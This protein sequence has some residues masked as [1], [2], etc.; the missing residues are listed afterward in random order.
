MFRAERFDPDQWADLFARSGAKYIALTSKHH[1]GFALWRT[2]EANRAWGRP[3]N[4]VDR[5]ETGPPAGPLR[6]PQGPSHVG[7]YYSLY[8]WYSPLWLSDRKRCVA[9]HLFPQLKRRLNHAKPRIIFSDG[10]WEMT[11][12]EWRATE[13]LAWLFNVSPCPR[14]G[15][16]Q[17]PL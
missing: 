14:R 5:S 11:R 9:E 4:S 3:W 10:E 17:R 15:R 1:E 16:D 12:E 2:A 8:E 6:L 13:L 7:I